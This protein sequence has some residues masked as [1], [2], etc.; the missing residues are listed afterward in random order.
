MTKLMQKN[1]QLSVATCRV[2]RKEGT[3]YEVKEWLVPNKTLTDQHAL[4][5]IAEIEE[6]FPDINSS[7]IRKTIGKTQYLV[8]GTVWSPPNSNDCFLVKWYVHKDK[9]VWPFWCLMI[10]FLL[11]VA[12]LGFGFYSGNGKVDLNKAMFWVN[13]PPF[14]GTVEPTPAQSSKHDPNVKLD[15]SIRS[16]LDAYDRTLVRKNKINME[17]VFKEGA[18]NQ[19]VLSVPHDILLDDLKKIDTF[20]Y[21]FN[22]LEQMKTDAKEILKTTP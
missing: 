2:E 19:G 1:L 13:K 20:E 6:G 17:R 5:V 9:L 22:S 11:S 15:D 16:V 7:L 21:L 12:A 18:T 14:E 3:G 4:D 8:V 10:L